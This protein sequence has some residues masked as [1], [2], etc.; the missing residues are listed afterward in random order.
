M[1]NPIPN[2]VIIGCGPKK[3]ELSKECLIFFKNLG[4]KVD[5]LDS[6]LAAST[7]NFCSEDDINVVGFIIPS[8]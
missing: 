1:M 7:F 8:D 3:F 4:I 5:V 6:F 2:Y